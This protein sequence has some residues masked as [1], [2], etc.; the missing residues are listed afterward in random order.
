MYISDP[1]IISLFKPEHV[2]KEKLAADAQILQMAESFLTFSHNGINSR[3]LLH[4]FFSN[5]PL[6]ADIITIFP[7]LAASSE[8][9]TMS[10]K[11][12]PSSIP[13]TSKSLHISCIS[14]NS[15]HEI[16]S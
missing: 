1:P 10:S 4:P 7:L 13:M 8:K 9:A 11:N 14:D 5:V 15:L 2:L 16:A 3:I 6:S 12:Y